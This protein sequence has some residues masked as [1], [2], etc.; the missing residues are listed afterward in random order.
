MYLYQSPMLPCAAA[1]APRAGQ[2]SFSPTH[3]PTRPPTKAHLAV[4]GDRVPDHVCD[5][6]RDEDD[7]DV[8]PVGEVLEALLD[9]AHRG[10]VVHD[11]EVGA[12]PQVDVA[13]AC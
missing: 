7:R 6:L 4:V 13:D 9:V 10:L 11:Q 12:F 1:M 5:R 2:P 3:P 8:L